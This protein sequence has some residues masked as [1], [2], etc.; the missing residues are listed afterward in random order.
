M[1]LTDFLALRRICGRSERSVGKVGDHYVEDERRV[2]SFIE[3]GLSALI[4]A[5][6]AALGE[7]EPDSGGIQQVRVTASGRARYEH[8]CDLQGIPPY[9]CIVEGTVEQ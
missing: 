4:D 7:P 2:L 6:H 8:L 3:D 5:G 9:P 1:E